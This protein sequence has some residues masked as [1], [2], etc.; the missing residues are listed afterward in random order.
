[1]SDNKSNGFDLFGLNAL[2]R[3]G[4]KLADASIEGIKAFLSLTCT[5]LLEELGLMGRDKVASWRMNNIMRMLEKAQGKLKYDPEEKKLTI[6][7]RVAFQIA[8]H[9][10][11]VS[12][13]TLQDMW[14]GL[15]ASSVNR[16]EEDENIFFIDILKRLTAAQVKL[17]SHICEHSPKNINIDNIDQEE[18]DGIVS[19]ENLHLDYKDRCEIMGSNSKLKVDTEYD[20]LV[21]MGLIH[22]PKYRF[23]MNLITSH[24]NRNSLLPTLKALRLYIKCQGS[25]KTPFQYFFN[26]ISKFYFDLLKDHVSIEQEETFDYIRTQRANGSKYVNDIEYRDAFVIK[27]GTWTKL[28]ILILNERL[29]AYF[30]YS[31]LARIKGEFQV[32]FE[33][34]E[35]GSFT[36]KNGFKKFD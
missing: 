17:I 4:E 18:A 19:T 15:F 2:G 22:N 6:D 35:I 8:E 16:Y 34:E 25:N 1:M 11:T 21:E 26:D 28:D 30:I 31:D 3:T 36:F 12:N 13:D 10:S 5:P 24:P 27:N 9:A 32:R 7:P 29:R 23:P 14:A 20:S 33:H